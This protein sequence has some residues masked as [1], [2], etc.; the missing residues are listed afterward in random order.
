MLKRGFLFLCLFVSAALFAADELPPK[1]ARYFNDYAGMVSPATASALNEQLAQFERATSNQILV[2][3]FNRLPESAALEDFTTRTFHAWE[4]GQKGKSNGAV[5]FIFKDNR[6]LFIQTGYGLEGALPDAVCKRIVEEEITPRFKQ[7]DFN[8]GVR[9]GV[10]AM[11]AAAKGEDKGTGR[12][13]A[14]QHG[15]R[16]HGFGLFPWLLG[17]FFL[18]IFLRV[19][20]NLVRSM[21]TLNEY[22]SPGWFGPMG[23]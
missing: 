7:G 23:G 2:A 9:A 18:I 20:R 8:G 1:P 16:S 5:L 13:V 17:F 12:T 11:L 19:L 10:N 22:R 4:V 6:K 3:I 14:D 15:S 21:Y